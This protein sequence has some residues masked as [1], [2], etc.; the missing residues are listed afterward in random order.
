M[1]LPATLIVMAYVGGVG[2]LWLPCIMVLLAG[3]LIRQLYWEN[4]VSAY[5]QEDPYLYAKH[6]YYP[7]DCRLDGL[8]G[9]CITRLEII[10]SVADPLP[11]RHAREL[12]IDS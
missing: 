11:E 4:F 1:V 2:R 5:V 9:P 12:T 3:L 6:I 7:T 10:A 8:P